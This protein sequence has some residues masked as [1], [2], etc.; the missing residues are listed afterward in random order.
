MASGIYRLPAELLL[1]IFA[2]LTKQD[3]AALR[4]TSKHLEDIASQIYLDSVTIAVRRKTL[5]DLDTITRHPG[6]RKGVKRVYF[7]ISQYDDRA[8]NIEVYAKRLVAKLRDELRDYLRFTCKH[9]HFK[10]MVRMSRKYTCTKGLLCDPK[11]IYE[12]QDW[13]KLCEGFPHRSIRNNLWLTR[14]D[15]SISNGYERYC[16]LAKDQKLLEKSQTHV[17]LFEKALKHLPLVKSLWVVDLSSASMRSSITFDSRNGHSAFCLDRTVISDPKHMAA[18][19][20]S[21]ILLAWE[22]LGMHL[23]ELTCK[24]AGAWLQML[25]IWEIQPLPPPFTTLL[26]H[27][28]TL[29][30]KIYNPRRK[31][32][33]NELDVCEVV[34]WWSFGDAL[35]SMLSQAE[36]LQ[37]LTIDG[38]AS[39]GPLHFHMIEMFGSAWKNLKHIGLKHLVIDFGEFMTFCVLRQTTLVSLAFDDVTMD[40]GSWHDAL[41]IFRIAL[42]LESIRFYGIQNLGFPD[43]EETVMA[44]YAMGRTEDLINLLR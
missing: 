23:E 20:L 15:S 41:E 14:R 27:V 35:G 22:K 39:V 9:H 30:L 11:R 44:L 43:S 36:A 38:S 5:V 4:L 8:T 6:L 32:G 34:E 3:L 24:E 10:L 42:R 26:K 1:A 25:P 37:S 29:E 28:V 18:F 19:H 17:R 7:D 40:G 2:P 31:L 13:I 12:L 21:R 33:G 16:E